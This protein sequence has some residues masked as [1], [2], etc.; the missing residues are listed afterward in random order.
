MFCG[1]FV[2]FLVFYGLDG[3]TMGITLAGER[4]VGFISTGSTG[5]DFTLWILT[6]EFFVVVVFDDCAIVAEWTG[7]ETFDRCLC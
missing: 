6:A 4:D 7:Y 5:Y 2:F 1:E 3:L